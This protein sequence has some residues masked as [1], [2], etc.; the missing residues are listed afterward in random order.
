[1]LIAPNQTQMTALQIN[2]TTKIIA[3]EYG[4]LE[5]IFIS[6]SG[7]GAPSWIGKKLLDLPDLL[8]S[9]QVAEGRPGAGSLAG[10]F[11]FNES[12]LNGYTGDMRFS[13]H[14]L[15]AES[16]AKSDINLKTAV[17]T[18]HDTAWGHKFRRDSLGA[19]LSRGQCLL[20]KNSV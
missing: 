9:H 5:E 4:F 12:S 6:P 2:E 7:E 14:E 13:A 8:L 19:P 10:Q 1:M 11:Q 3:D 17:L 18:A 15:I 20:Y 16:W